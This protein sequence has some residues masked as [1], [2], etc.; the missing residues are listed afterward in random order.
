M[1]I[2]LPDF[3]FGTAIPKK[4]HQIY[5]IY[6]E[7]PDEIKENVKRIQAL[8]P[9]WKH[10]FHD[11]RDMENLI[12]KY[13]GDEILSLYLTIN[14]SY[15]AARADFFRYLL[16]YAEGGVY[17]DTKSSMNFPLDEVL[18]D[19][20]YIL[21]KWKN[22]PEDPYTSWG[23]HKELD[24][25]SGGEYQQWQIVCA[26]GH[27]FLKSV[28]KKVISEIQNYSVFKHGYGREGVLRTTGPIPYTLA[29]E[30]IKNQYSYREVDV[31]KELGFIYSI[32]EN[33]G[34][35]NKHTTIFSK[36]YSKLKLPIIKAGTKYY[37][38]F[39]LCRLTRIIKKVKG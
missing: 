26:A 6:T 2:M 5:S 25:Y 21:S 32:Y 28:I 39:L 33:S 10:Y 34:N 16:M 4:I 30:N 36:H 7:M 24:K 37:L 29:I 15:G 31:I 12:H 3:E 8:N 17:L 35:A 1:P 27:P 9:E 22:G 11:E 18:N 20:T 38:D 23:L 13:Y 14:S 19:E